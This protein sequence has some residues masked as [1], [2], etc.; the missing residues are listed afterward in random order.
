M[1]P[2]KDESGDRYLLLK[3]STESS[4]V[5]DLSTGERRHLPNEDLSVV[6]AGQPLEVVAS[7]LAADRRDRL[8][9]S[10]D[11][12]VGVL[13]ELVQG[14]PRPVRDLL[15]RTE[16][17]ESDLN[18]IVGELRAA[19]LVTETTVDG[20]RGYGATETAADLLASEDG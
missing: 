18:G 10:D 5:R 3:R 20:R 9:V 14:G 17:C 15:G 4:L 19:G 6:G 13:V 11:R 12:A 8:P 1:R 16:L 2:V 7:A